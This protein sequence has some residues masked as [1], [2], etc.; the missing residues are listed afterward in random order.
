MNNKSNIK[1]KIIII[2]VVSKIM[3][4]M[5]QK[6]CLLNNNYLLNNNKIHISNSKVEGSLK[7]LK[8]KR[9]KKLK[10]LIIYINNKSK[11]QMVIYNSNII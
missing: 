6:Y 5:M 9:I 8:K 4:N 2:W 3:V 1:C 10:K 7:Y 11:D